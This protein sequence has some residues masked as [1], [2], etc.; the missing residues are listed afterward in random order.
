MVAADLLVENEFAT[1]IFA[2]FLNLAIIC[3]PSPTPFDR[4]LA[5][6]RL[7]KRVQQTRD[8]LGQIRDACRQVW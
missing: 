1:K 8:A 4:E 6:V 2:V 5:N 3:N 7:H